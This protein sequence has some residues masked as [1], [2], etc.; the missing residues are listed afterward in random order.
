MTPE[1]LK[2]KT[3]KTKILILLL[4]LPFLSFTQN[5]NLRKAILKS[6]LIIS[7]NDFKMDTVRVNDFTSKVYININAI[8][9]QNSW[10]YKNNLGSVPKKLSLRKL[11]DGEDFYS[12]LITDGNA[13][14]HRALN[15]SITYHDLFFIK[16]EKNE[17]KIVALYESLEWEQLEK[18]GKQVK[19]F[20]GIE[21]I[22]N[23]NERYQKSLDWFIENGL[24]P[25]NDFVDY[26]KEK[27]VIKDSIIYNE[28]QY[29]KAL[30]EFQTGKEELLPMLREKYFNEVKA[31]YLQKLENIFKID[32][33]ECNDY[34]DFTN[35]FHSI[36]NDELAYDSSDYLLYSS[37]TSDKF[38]EYD[39]RRIMQHLMEVFKDW[40]LKQK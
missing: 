11:I 31:Y 39:K 17:Y 36:V 40:E 19:S 9:E 6:D 25:D 10:V 14:M 34:Y 22:K 24:M 38:D 35:A 32:K 37:L 30:Q 29:I 7:I 13:C 16:K 20:A 27:N 18:I 23:E 33:P 8:N 15:G 2:N 1:L 4:I 28:T 5:Q 21:K 26:Y 3:M 12:Y